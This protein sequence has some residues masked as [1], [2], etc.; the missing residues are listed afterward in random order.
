[1]HV[2]NILSLTFGVLLLVHVPLG[3]QTT[4]AS[5][6]D[7]S[8]GPGFRDVY[9]TPEV[10]EVDMANSPRLDRLLRGGK[11]YLS[12]S[13]AI[14]LAIENN[15][16]IAYARYG[17]RIADTDILRTKSGQQLRGVQTQISTLSTGQ[18]AAGGGGGAGGGDVTGITGRAGGVGGG[19]Q[20]VGDASTFFGSAVPSLEP[21]LTGGIDWG[22][23]SNPQTS[24]FVSGTNTFVFETSN[25]NI[26]IQ[27]GFLTGT[28]VSLDWR[29]TLNDTNSLRANFDPSLRSNVT[30]RISQSLLQ[31]FGRSVNSRNIRIAKNNRAVSDLAFEAQ[32]IATVTQVQNLYWDLVSF[33]AEVRSRE[34]DLRLAQKLYE[35]NKRRVEIG[36]LA[37]IEIVRA[38]VE[39]ASREQDLTLA[40]TRVQ[41]QETT[42]KNAVSKNGLASPSI[43]DVEIVPTDRIEVPDREEIQ[44]LQ[45]LMS[46]ALQSR[47]ELTQSRIQLKNQ[48]ISLK[49]VRNAIL[50]QISIFADLTNNALAGRLNEDFI[51]FPGIENVVSDFFVGGLGT[52]LSQVLRR[53]FPDYQI[54]VR[55]SFPLKNRRAQ[56]DMTAT[57]LERRRA[58]IQ[59]RQQENSIRA[60][61]RDAVIGVQQSRARFTAAE[62]TRIL[63][64]RTLDAEQKKFKLGASTI[65]F[66]VEAQR[67][68]ALAR[69][70]EIAAQNNYIKSKVALDRATGKT[71]GVNNIAIDEAYDGRVS[72]SPDPIPPN[73]EAARRSPQG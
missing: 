73:P 51:G 38:E 19:A 25:S 40:V 33:R 45:D 55:V 31:G 21:T 50:P 72:K 48:D 64:E 16:D 4:A 20:G 53:N 47:P 65:F 27:K 1:M 11:L 6:I 8:T 41:L 3:A 10:P 26:G 62:K 66:V 44:P 15:L 28:N 54:G 71:L 36:V 59:L 63:Q 68:L 52:S 43:L 67:D 46:L 18:S 2:K 9:K 69:S 35:D 58:D 60:E 32:V 42:I 39:V 7:Y 57:L 5:A 34:E 24:S 22:H 17:P 61:V 30:L 12:L 23:F 70:A 13:D 49:G 14:A 56:A 37:P 29:N